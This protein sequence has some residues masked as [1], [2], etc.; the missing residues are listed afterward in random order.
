MT[1]TAEDGTT[2]IS[3]YYEKD[4]KKAMIMSRIKDNENE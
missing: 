4:G 3:D 2:I 1:S